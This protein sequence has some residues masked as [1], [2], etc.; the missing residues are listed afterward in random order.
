MFFCASIDGI[1]MFSSQC[2]KS[3]KCKRIF[4]PLDW[5]CDD[6]A[7]NDHSNEAKKLRERLLKEEILKLKE[8][9]KNGRI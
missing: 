9:S 1:D 7:V 2:G 4:V 3:G 6:W 5:V 8:K